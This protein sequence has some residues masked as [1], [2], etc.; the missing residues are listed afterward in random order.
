MGSLPVV[1]LL[2]SFHALT[3]V[4]QEPQPEST[5][6]PAATVPPNCREEMY[7]CTRMYSVHRPIKQC[8]GA[9][10]FYSLPRVYVINKEICMRTVCPQDEYRKA[11]RCRELSGWPRR[12][13]RSTK[14]N[15]CRHRLGN[16]KTWANMA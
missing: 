10:C 8:V 2:C 7:P 12:V 16:T 9:M 13:E 15:D 1:L 3:A 11:E 4:A 5:A 6:A 14:R